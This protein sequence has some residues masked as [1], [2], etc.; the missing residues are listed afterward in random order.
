M[1]KRNPYPGVKKVGVIHTL[2]RKDSNAQRRNSHKAVR[3][4]GKKDIDTRSLDIESKFHV[5]VFRKGDKVVTPKNVEY[6]TA[7]P[8]MAMHIPKGTQGKVLKL[9]KEQW[10]WVHFPSLKGRRVGLMQPNVDVVR[11]PCSEDELKKLY[12]ANARPAPTVLRF[13][14]GKYRFEI[15]RVTGPG[16]DDQ[17]TVDEVG[18]F[19]G[20]RAAQAMAQRLTNESGY[21]HITAEYDASNDSAYGSFLSDYPYGTRLSVKLLGTDGS[22]EDDQQQWFERNKNKRMMGTVV[23]EDDCAYFRPD[24]VFLGKV[25]KLVLHDDEIEIKREPKKTY[26]ATESK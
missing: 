20:E 6:A 14:D 3:R 23:K 1:A 2:S 26:S 19:A 17:V 5:P 16:E 12:E 25:K 22:W 9:D 7:V 18:T 8:S 13:S 21:E 10:L 4:A 24:A 15:W 11:V